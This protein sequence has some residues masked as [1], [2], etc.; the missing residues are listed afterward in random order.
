MCIRTFYDWPSQM[1][2]NLVISRIKTQSKSTNVSAF[3]RPGVMDM[4]FSIIVIKMFNK[5]ILIDHIFHFDRSPIILWRQSA[6][7]LDRAWVGCC[8][9]RHTPSDD[10]VIPRSD[11]NDVSRRDFQLSP[12]ASHWKRMLTHASKLRKRL[13][14]SIKWEELSKQDAKYTHRNGENACF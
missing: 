5:R 12:K 11:S 4:Y 7:P 8:P 6:E 9:R 1:H 14:L 10:Y 13:L 3:V 2:E